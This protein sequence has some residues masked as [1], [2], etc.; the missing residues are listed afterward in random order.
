MSTGRPTVCAVLTAFNRREQTVRSLKAFFAQVGDL[1]LRAVLMDDGSSDGTTEAV[2][3]VLPSVTVLNGDGSLFWN[4]GMAAAYD[5]AR[6]MSADYYL[7][8]ND[9]TVLDADALQRLIGDAES[10]RGAQGVIV[11]GSARDP[12]TAHL[13]YGGLRA[14][15]S[16][17]AGKFSLIEPGLRPIPCAAMNGNIVLVD[18]TAAELTG[19]IDT[20]FTHSMGDYDYA[21]SANRLGVQVVVG[22]G[23]FGVCPR[24]PEGSSWTEQSSIRDRYQQARS[25]KGLPPSEWAYFLRKHGGLLWPLAWLFS[26]RRIL[27]G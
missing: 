25:P 7:W 9:D 14:T 13:T 23:S 21:L 10:L 5:A 24:N 1:D 6:S 22:S 16:W 17:H 18:Q 15:S 8:L 11:V 20:R 19:G 26:Y 27:T 2:H 12:V 4:G 3:R